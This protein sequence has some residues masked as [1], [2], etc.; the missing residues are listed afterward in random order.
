MRIRIVTNSTDRDSVH[1]MHIPYWKRAHHD[2]RFWI[3]LLSMIATMIVYAVSE[4]FAWLHRG[5]LR[6]PHQTPAENSSTP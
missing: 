5:P 4:D 6:P 3:A 2:W 1:D